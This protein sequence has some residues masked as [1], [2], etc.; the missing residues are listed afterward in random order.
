MK[1][2]AAQQNSIITNYNYLLSFTDNTL[3][4]LSALLHYLDL[5]ADYLGNIQNEIESLSRDICLYLL[6]ITKETVTH[7]NDLHQDFWQF[8]MFEVTRRH[9]TLK[10]KSYSKQM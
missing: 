9:L 6:S 7:T 10:Q 5:L 4:L 3:I 8:Y 2:P 1:I